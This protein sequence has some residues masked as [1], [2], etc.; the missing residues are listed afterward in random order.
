MLD[1]FHFAS[2]K[3]CSSY[4][5]TDTRAA[6]FDAVHLEGRKSL[7]CA[8]SGVQI[9][10]RRCRQASSVILRKAWDF[11]VKGLARFKRAVLASGVARG[12]DH[13]EINCLI[14]LATAGGVHQ[15]GDAGT[16][17]ATARMYVQHYAAIFRYIRKRVG[18][19]AEAED[20]TG[21][22]FCKAV[23]G[24][25]NYRSL[26]P[27]VLPWLYTIAA[28]RVIDHYRSNRPTSRLDESVLSADGDANPADVVVNKVL[29]SEV[30]DVA[31]ELPA[32][33]R[34]ALW[35]RYGEELELGEIALLMGRSVEA[36]KLLVH[37]AVRAVRVRM[38]VA[39]SGPALLAL[40]APS[41]SHRGTGSGRS[42]RRPRSTFTTPALA[43]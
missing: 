37:R 4:T 29:V 27:S 40:P 25:K 16:E 15:L 28:N 2:P 26:R 10:R 14:D 12:S 20:L 18:T 8:H 39:G 21:D 35:L 22:V 17:S 32:S 34:R 30:W 5:V 43:L 13:R 11:K 41:A 1:V 9:R 3:I 38:V 36:V 6:V 33:Q 24:A 23:A 19:R 7:P 31:K 42:R